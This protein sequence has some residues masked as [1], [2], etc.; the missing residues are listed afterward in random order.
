MKTH[1]FRYAHGGE[2]TASHDVVQNVFA[3]IAKKMQ[4][5]CFAKTNPRSFN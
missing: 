5:S 1:F 4:V 2:R 3:S